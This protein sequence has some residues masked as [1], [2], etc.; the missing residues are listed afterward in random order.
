M[1]EL[2]EFVNENFLIFNPP[3]IKYTTTYWT[4]LP[5]SWT[6]NFCQWRSAEGFVEKDWKTE[7]TE[8]SSDNHLI[9]PSDR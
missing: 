9:E 1:L 7:T 6:A 3:P 4:Y 8:E 5:A 2:N